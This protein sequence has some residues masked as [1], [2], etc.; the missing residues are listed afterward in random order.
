MDEAALPP[1]LLADVPALINHSAHNYIIINKIND[2]CDLGETFARLTVDQRAD[3]R[4]PALMTLI[5][6]TLTDARRRLRYFAAL[7]I[8]DWRCWRKWFYSP[9]KIRGSEVKPGGGGSWRA[10]EVM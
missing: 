1:L 8:N 4:V 6:V 3:R 10:S 7:I 2:V 5:K 9:G